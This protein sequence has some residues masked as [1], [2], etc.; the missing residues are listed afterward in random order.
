[1]PLDIVE[2]ER[3]RNQFL[4][5]LL[6]LAEE[7]M[8]RDPTA[9]ITCVAFD[10]GHIAERA[11]ISV[12]EGDRIA[13][14]LLASGLIL[15]IGSGSLGQVP[16]ALTLDGVQVAERIRYDKTFL[17]KRRA[18]V[19][20]MREGGI[21]AGKSLW[22]YGLTWLGGFVSGGVVFRWSDLLRWF[23]W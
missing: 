21:E 8:S 3:R 1:M 18:A 19:R 20:V 17:A 12:R 15:Y 11:G 14:E 13:D 22:R 9:S 2:H 23:G 16:C 10:D 4:V 7:A 6:N 5:A